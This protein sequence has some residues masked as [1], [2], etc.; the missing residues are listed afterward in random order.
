MIEE[1]IVLSKVTSYSL[2]ILRKP[3]PFY[4]KDLKDLKSRGVFVDANPYE[5][6]VSL[7]R[8]I[9]I[10]KFIITNITKFGNK[11]SLVIGLKTLWWFLF[12]K[13][14]YLKGE[15]YHAQFATQ[16]SLLALM[17]C[18]FNSFESEFSFTFHAYDI[19]FKNKWFDK[20]A[21]SSSCLFSI[22]EYNKKYVLNNYKVVNKEN[23]I[24]SRLGT[25]K[26]HNIDEDKIE[27]YGSHVK[28]ELTIGFISWFVEKKGITYLL[29]A[30]NKLRLDNQRVK[31]LLAGD[32]PI[33]DKVIAKIEEFNLKQVVEY[34]GSVNGE[35]K[36]I[37]FNEI[38]ILALPAISM[39]DDRD[40]IPV[41]LMEACSY[42]VPIL[43]TDVSGIPE[44]CI[45]GYNGFLIKERDTQAIYDSIKQFKNDI[46]MQN[47]MSKNAFRLFMEKYEIEKN[48]LSKAK[49][50]K[51][52]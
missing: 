43:T 40:G 18:E 35:E 34:L 31:L 15:N 36:K 4:D 44:I 6:K 30:L 41:V 52:Y 1:L 25:S 48:T 37:F 13:E 21:N 16:A 32:G 23:I 42:G 22:S 51:W 24:L 2:V 20:L 28:K 46:D 45:N 29:E 3:F 7:K 8:L 17:I 9:F 49:H 47:E 12:I 14:E 5:K 11:Y 38:D 27:L 50:M 10:F 26:P 19:F 39:K 33:K